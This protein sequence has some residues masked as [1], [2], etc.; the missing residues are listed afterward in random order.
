MLIKKGKKYARICKDTEHYVLATWMTSSYN[1]I[2]C[3][4]GDGA[5]IDDA[6]AAKTRLEWKEFLFLIWNYYV[7]NA[8]FSS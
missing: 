8:S 4:V 3:N 1:H 2:K 7:I 6:I 5:K